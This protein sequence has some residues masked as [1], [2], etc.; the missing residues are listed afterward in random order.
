MFVTGTLSNFYL[1]PI[2]GDSCYSY[3][4]FQDHAVSAQ[5]KGPR[6]A[7][8]ILKAE[9]TLGTKLLATSQTSHGQL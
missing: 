7:S 6:C 4:A 8:A 9:W 1:R 2:L 5:G 3:C